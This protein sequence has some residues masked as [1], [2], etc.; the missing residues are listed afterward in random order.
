MRDALIVGIS[1]ELL[2]RRVK[3]D[4]TSNLLPQRGGVAYIAAQLS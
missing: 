4:Q 1:A 3:V 2:L